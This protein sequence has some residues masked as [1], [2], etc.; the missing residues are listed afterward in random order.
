MAGLGLL[1]PGLLVALVVAAFYLWARRQGHLGAPAERAVRH[2]R[3]SLLTEALAYVG[4]VL[5]LGGGIAAV[6]QRWSD[7]SA[8]GHVG[9]LA[10]GAVLFLAAGV[11]LRNVADE[12]VQRLVS[13]LWFVSVGGVAAAV[14]LA[15][16]D[17]GG[18]S[19][20]TTLLVSG[21]TTTAYAAALWLPRRRALQNAAL[22]GSLVVAVCGV[23]AESVPSPPA[24]AFAL[25]L[26]ALGLTWAVLGWLRVAEPE[27][28][29]MPLGV[30]LALVAPA[31]G[32]TDHGWVFAIAIGTAGALMAAS[33]PLRNVPLLAVATVSMFGYL[34]ALLVRYFADSLGVPAALAIAGLLILG[35]ALVSA[36]L[37]RAA[38]PPADAA[39]KGDDSGDTDEEERPPQLRR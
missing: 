38:R 28:T 6:R 13:V 37:L 2:T 7:I 14:A 19:G 3:G 36:R 26:W 16:H 23:V 1:L 11:V 20:T 22:L 39:G 35:L 31:V 21:L 8:W 25:A 33:V 12:A 34:T 17:I 24:I 27:W 32:I 10:G 4:A 9:L 15:T 29:S 30:L 5:L 18:T